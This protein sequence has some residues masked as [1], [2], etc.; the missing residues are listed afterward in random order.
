MRFGYSFASVPGQGFFTTQFHSLTAGPEYRIDKRNTASVQ[1]NGQRMQFA[2]GNEFNSTINVV[3]GTLGWEHMFSPTFSVE[4]R[5]G[6]SVLEPGS[7]F[8]YIGNLS[9][10]WT[11]QRAS[12]ALTFS[13]SVFPSF[14]IAAVPLASN[15]VAASVTYRFTEKLGGGGTVNYARNESVPAGLITFNSYGATFHLDYAVSRYTAVSAGYTYNNFETTFV[16]AGYE[17]S[18]SVL[19]ASLKTEWR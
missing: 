13:R 18:R 17:F 8:L 3:G 12:T 15:V 10:R 2:Q 4:G 6:A 16:G 7:E 14:F 11:R 9:A 19:S 1:V 5:L